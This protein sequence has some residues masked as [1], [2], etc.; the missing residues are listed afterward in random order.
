MEDNSS[1][2]IVEIAI[3]HDGKVNWQQEW[4]VPFDAFPT[5]DS[6]EH[7]AGYLNKYVRPALYRVREYKPVE[8]E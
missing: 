4:P 1:V 3:Y 7:H 5:K 6:A 2:W 8:K